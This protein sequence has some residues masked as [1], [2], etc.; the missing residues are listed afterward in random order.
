MAVPFILGGIA[1]ATGIFGAKKAYDGYQDKCAAEELDNNAKAI[2]NYAKENL[3]V[4]R[5]NAEQALENLGHAKLH[6]HQNSFK[7]FIDIFS[8]LKNVES[9]DFSKDDLKFNINEFIEFTKESVIDFTKLA[10]GGI[11]S[12]GAGALAGLGAYGSVG[13]LAS[14]STGTLISTLSG[15]AATNATLAW[16]GGGSLAAGGFGMAGGMAVL[17]GIVAAPVLAVGGFLYSK[18][19]EQ[20]LDEA[21]SNLHKAKAAASEMDTARI[22]T[23][24]ISSIVNESLIA[25]QNLDGVLI[26]ELQTFK[27][28]IIRENDYS[29]FTNGEKAY[30][31]FIVNL[32]KAISG[33]CKVNVLT[34][35]GIVNK[36]FKKAVQIAQ[37]LNK[38][39]QTI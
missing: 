4:A 25:I 33:I 9:S 20:A 28:M 36:E 11:A 26:K 21:K 32:V 35:D 10:A 23:T 12:L 14:A 19:G 39:I 5:K 15:A 27:L 13:L 34:E 31:Q 37:N 2:F 18:V 22:A 24:A 7:E 38:E 29:K 8:K 30:T 17:G 6:I 3:D 1:L 16:L